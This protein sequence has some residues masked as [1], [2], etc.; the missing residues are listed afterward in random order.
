MARLVGLHHAETNESDGA[1]DDDDD[2]DRSLPE[3]F[4]NPYKNV[5]VSQLV[6]NMASDQDMEDEIAETSTTSD[7][8]DLESPWGSLDERDSA[9][10]GDSQRLI[11]NTLHQV[12]ITEDQEANERRQHN[13]HILVPELNTMVHKAK[14]IKQ[15]AKNKKVSSDRLIRVQQA[16]EPTDTA[17][18]EVSDEVSDEGEDSRH[19]VGLWDDIAFES[20]HRYDDQRPYRMAQVLRMRLVTSTRRRTEYVRPVNLQRDSGKSIELLVR[21]YTLLRDQLFS[22]S[23]STEEV[24]ISDVITPVSLTRQGEAFHL[25]LADSAYLEAYFPLETGDEATEYMADDGR[26][27]QLCRSRTGRLRRAVVCTSH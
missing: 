18:D 4:V 23:C 13:S 12:E 24:S 6:H 2:D 27:V 10:F 25:S 9:L 3:W 7:A 20:D 21:P 1:T 19:N 16:Q 5:T 17:S 8:S 14:V 26:R 15:L 11:S 22:T